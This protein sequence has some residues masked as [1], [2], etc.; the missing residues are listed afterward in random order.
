MEIIKAH[1][2][3]NLCYQAAQKMRP[4]GIVV[5]STGANNPNLWR[6]VN[7]PE[8]VG[9]N[10]RGNHWDIPEPEGKKLCVHAFIGLDKNGDV[11]VAELLPLD[12]CCWGVGRGEKGSYNDTVPHIQ[13]EI[14]EDGLDNKDYYDKAFGLAVEYCAHLCRSYGIAPDRIVGHCEAHKKGYGSNHRDPEHWMKKY[15]DS[16]GAFRMRVVRYLL[17]EDHKSEIEN[18]NEITFHKGDLV[19]L[20]HDA[21]YYDGSQI[22]LWVKTQSWY[23]KEDPIGDRAVI[24]RN[25]SGINSICSPICTEFLIKVENAG[26]K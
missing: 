14:C 20:R 18:N 5:H 12:I 3:N 8:E 26:N 22:P 25:E 1:A 10:K 17:S 19:K 24:D 15:D 2:T 11:R 23:I 7:C 16:M 4:E 21:V 9:E 13:F 6:Y